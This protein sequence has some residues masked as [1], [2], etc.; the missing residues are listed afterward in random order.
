MAKFI[1]LIEQ[2][3]SSIHYVNLEH[4]V[5][6]IH[7]PNAP[8]ATVCLADGKS[9]RVGEMETQRLVSAFGEIGNQTAET[10]GSKPLN[11]PP[12]EVPTRLS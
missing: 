9:F 3:D 8:V 5:Q 11:A 7:V 4:I 10:A 2:G 6:I 12:A 1:P